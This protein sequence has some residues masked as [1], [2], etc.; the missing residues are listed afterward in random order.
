MPFTEPAQLIQPFLQPL[1]N[2]FAKGISLAEQIRQAN[3]RKPLLLAQTQLAQ[4]KV[5]QTQDIAR[6]YHRLYGGE[7]Q[8]FDESVSTD[9]MML[10][11]PVAKSIFKAHTGISLPDTQYDALTI[12]GPQGQT[13]RIY[14]PKGSKYTPPEEWSLKAPGAES[15]PTRYRIGNKIVQMDKDN[16]V[17]TFTIPG[18]PEPAEQ[19]IVD[20]TLVSIYPDG[21]TETMPI[22]GLPPEIKTQIIGNQAVTTQIPQGGGQ[23]SFGVQ[24]V[25]GLEQTTNQ[26]IA[27]YK[28][29]AL[30]R[31][32][33]GNPLPQDVQILNLYD[34]ILG[35]AAQMVN[36][37]LGMISK[38]AEEKAQA[39][40]ALAETLRNAQNMQFGVQDTAKIAEE[41]KDQAFLNELR[42]ILSPQGSVPAA[43]PAV[44]QPDML[45]SMPQQPIQQPVLQN[46]TVSQMAPQRPPIIPQAPVIDQQGRTVDQVLKKVAKPASGQEP[47]AQNIPLQDAIEVS[48][49]VFVYKDDQGNIFI[50]TPNVD[51]FAKIDPG[52]VTYKI[53]S[54]RWNQLKGQ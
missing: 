48:E 46:E 21:R 12:Y 27:M 1:S 4:Q 47:N 29:G 23:P 2:Q 42:Q 38:S 3:L 53:F 54:R 5:K 19:R 24:P 11:D 35:R 34:P 31:Y 15:K 26:Q 40:I 14:H 10:Q 50:K 9:K 36:Q 22:A 20:G 52:S 41:Q 7:G 33:S 28:L 49:G 6:A 8:P 25:P 16:R 18:M 30:T 13:Q 37:D 44:S 51:N 39:A 32:Y 43:P 17:Q 45:P